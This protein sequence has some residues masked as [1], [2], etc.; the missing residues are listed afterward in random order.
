MLTFYT[1]THEF[2]QGKNIYN[3]SPHLHGLGILAKTPV[4]LSDSKGCNLEAA[5]DPQCHPENK[6]KFWYRKGKDVHVN[7][8]YLWLKDNLLLE[9]QKSGTNHITL[10]MFGWVHAT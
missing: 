5:V 2:I 9:L 6:I 10:D 8:Q 3:L 7:D 4:I 1:I